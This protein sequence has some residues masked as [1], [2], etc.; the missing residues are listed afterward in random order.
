MSKPFSKPFFAECMECGERFKVATLPIQVSTLATLTK[1]FCPNCG[2]GASRLG[3]CA[4]DGPNAVT[5]PRDGA[6]IRR[7][8]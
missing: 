8:Q 5:A 7:D 6:P 1:M 3:L 4:T 2:T